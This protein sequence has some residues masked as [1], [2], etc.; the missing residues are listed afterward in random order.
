MSLVETFCRV[1]GKMSYTRQSEVLRGRGRYCSWSCSNKGRN[2]KKKAIEPISEAPTRKVVNQ[3]ESSFTLP[4]EPYNITISKLLNGNV[5][6]FSDTPTH[7]VAPCMA[8][9]IKTVE[10]TILAHHMAGVDVLDPLY[11]KGLEEILHIV[12]KTPQ[13]EIWGNET[14]D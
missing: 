6:V 8:A 12:C 10:H 3:V 13:A 4:L 2:L 14:D 7:M 9:A 5:M 1:C 11:L